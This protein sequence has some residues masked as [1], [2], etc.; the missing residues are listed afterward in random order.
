VFPSFQKFTVARSTGWP[1]KS[2]PRLN[3]HQITLETGP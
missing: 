1:N 2:Q 3:C